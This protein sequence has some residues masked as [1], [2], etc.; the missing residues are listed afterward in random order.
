LVFVLA[1]GIVF[2]SHQH[3][4]WYLLKFWIK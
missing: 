1:Q 4:K 3:W 2:C